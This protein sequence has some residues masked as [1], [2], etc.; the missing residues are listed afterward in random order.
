MRSWIRDICSNRRDIP[1]VLK[2]AYARCNHGQQ[3]PDFKSLKKILKAVMD[4]FQHIYLIIDALDEYPKD[5]R[6]EGKSL[7]DTILETN[8][9]NIDSTHMFVTSRKED[10]IRRYI[11]DTAHR[12]T[13]GSFES[14][15]AQDPSV[16]EDIKRFLS[17]SLDT[18]GP[19]ILTKNAKLKNETVDT[20]AEKA[21]GMFRLAALQLESLKSYRTESKIREALRRLPKSLDIYYERALSKIPEDQNYVKIALQ[22][23]AYSARSILVLELLE[24][25]V[26]EIECPPYLDEND[27][28]EC[29]DTFELLEIIT[30]V[31]YTTYEKDDSDS[32]V[33]SSE[34]STVR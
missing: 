7:L 28:L 22:W 27:R 8:R 11:D 18:L 17:N 4:G 21:D 5:E 16:R 14:V 6:I 1:Q 32:V 10:D 19:R 12:G 29:G 34:N 3:Q 26:L 25:V 15:E 24:A 31:F 13:S 20:I 33:N 23:M 2:D 30:S 9:W